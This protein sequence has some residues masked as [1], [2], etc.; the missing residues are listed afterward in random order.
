[1]K[2]KI[3]SKYIN[4]KKCNTYFTRLIGFIGKKNIDYGLFFSKCNS[5]HT[6]FMRE[7]IDVIG[8]DENNKVIFKKEC[9][10]P[11]KFIN[12]NYKNNKT[13]ILELPKNTSLNIKINDVLCFEDENIV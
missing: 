8:L 9:V 10:D 4:I 1:M 5:I 12:I 6:L 11:Y 3:D 2:L 7:A 13:S